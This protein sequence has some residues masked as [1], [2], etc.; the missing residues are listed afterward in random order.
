MGHLVRLAAVLRKGQTSGL[1]PNE[2][3]GASFIAVS[4]VAFGDDH[5]HRSDKVVG[6]AVAPFPEK[7]STHDNGLHQ[8]HWLRRLLMMK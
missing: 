4:M 2:M 6:V 7:L 1:K 8:I 3:P 5:D